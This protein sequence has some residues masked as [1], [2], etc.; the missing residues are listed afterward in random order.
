MTV[1]ELMEQ[2]ERMPPDSHVDVMFHTGNDCYQINCLDL[3]ELR[4]GRKIVVVEI[5]DDV[6]LRAV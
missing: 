6:P 4:N 3:L 2:L 5:T 1:A